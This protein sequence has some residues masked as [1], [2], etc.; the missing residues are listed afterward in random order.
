MTHRLTIHRIVVLM[1]LLRL[2]H[3]LAALLASVVLTFTLV[4]DLV[5]YVGILTSDLVVVY[6]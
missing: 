4:S 2:L 6:Q 5:V 1:L 3:H